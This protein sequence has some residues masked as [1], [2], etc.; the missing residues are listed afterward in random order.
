MTKYLVR[1][2]YNGTSKLLAVQ[3]RNEFV[4]IRKAKNSRLSKGC[5][6]FMVIERASNSIV[7]TAANV[8]G[9]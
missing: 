6:A 5:C 7:L 9:D 2:I 3:G 1:C 8:V 4:A